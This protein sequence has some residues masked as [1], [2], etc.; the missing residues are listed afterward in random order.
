M[1]QQPH[2]HDF[3][4]AAAFKLPRDVRREQ[5][6]EE[7]RRS[8]ELQAQRKVYS[9]FEQT[10][11]QDRIQGDVREARNGQKEGVLVPVPR[12]TKK[13]RHDYSG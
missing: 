11:V 1:T 10:E 13:L 9:F 4:S 5:E 6:Q 3:E 7:R 2:L 12:R 8:V